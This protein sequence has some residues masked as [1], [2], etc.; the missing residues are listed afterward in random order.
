[1]PTFCELLQF[2]SS[3]LGGSVVDGAEDEF[4]MVDLLFPVPEIN[5][6]TVPYRADAAE[7]MR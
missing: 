3:S 6:N 5:D 7:P 1:M 2:F 4:P